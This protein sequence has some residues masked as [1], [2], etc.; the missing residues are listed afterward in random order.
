MSDR[1][2]A[3][4]VRMERMRCADISIDGTCPFNPDAKDWTASAA[5]EHARAL[6]ADNLMQ[7]DLRSEL[8]KLA[9]RLWSEA[10]NASREHDYSL[11]AL[12]NSVLMQ[13]DV[14][15]RYAAGL[16][17]LALENTKRGA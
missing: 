2:T 11:T 6:I 15:L 16:I 9:E 7:D 3:E 14:T 8:L 4:Q 12:Q 17:E 10:G 5:Y 1:L 13:R